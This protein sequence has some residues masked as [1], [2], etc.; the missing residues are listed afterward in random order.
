M[1]SRILMKSLSVAA[2]CSLGVA[3]LSAE[4]LLRPIGN[5]ADE[6]EEAIYLQEAKS[7]LSG[8]IEKYQSILE[9]DSVMGTIAAEA[10]FRI[11]ECYWD[12]GN[13]TQAILEYTKL[14]TQ[15]PEALEWIS[16]ADDRLPKDFSPSISPFVDGERSVYKYV[17]QTGNVV[18]FSAIVVKS[19]EYEGRTLW[20]S[21]HRIM[22]GAQRMGVVEFDPETYETVFSQILAHERDVGVV[23]CWYDLEPF[24]AKV[25]FLKSDKTRE[26][27]FLKKTYDNEQAMHLFRQLPADVGYAT[28][29]NVFVSLTG[30]SIPVQCEVVEILDV[31]TVIGTV[32][33][34]KVALNVA[35]M[36][37]A[38]YITNDERRIVVLMETGGVEIKLIQSDFEVEEERRKYENER[39]GF[40]FIHADEWVPFE[41]P[42]N[43]GSSVEEVKFLTPGGLAF[44]EVRCQLNSK[45][46]F[47]KS[48]DFEVSGQALFDMEKNRKSM[49]TFSE[50]SLVYSQVNGMDV[51]E[52]QGVRKN[53]EGQI[54]E[55]FNMCF[56]KGEERSFQ[57]GVKAGFE[58]WESMESGVDTIVGSLSE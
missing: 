58:D 14:K 17:L 57:V 15:F 56:L 5:V 35:G 19:Y 18:G 1:K 51:V 4:E 30:M 20:R 7:D 31:G 22:A 33:C 23:N 16:A 24:S 36:E 11:A 32:E 6:L 44:A 27:P 9:A 8:A 25:E 38:L 41:D 29:L 42:G 48:G 49:F 26:F 2:M 12:S 37:Q 54:V 52:F 40:S 53:D 3:F 39:F 50:D 46:G 45:I 13:K 21:E 47:L 10:Q 34:F 55:V 43:D 28:E